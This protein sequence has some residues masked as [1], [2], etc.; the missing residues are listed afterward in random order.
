MNCK[1]AA[2]LIPLFIEA[3]LET[4][5]MQSLAE[6][7]EMCD[8]CRSVAEEFQ[9][10]QS[11]LHSVALPEFHAAAFAQMRNSVLNEI[12]RPKI[13]DLLHPIWDWKTAFAASLAMIILTSGAVNYWPDA[14]EN[15]VAQIPGNSDKKHEFSAVASSKDLVKPS[16]VSSKVLK[17]RRGCKNIARGEV[18]ASERNPGKIGTNHSSPERATAFHTQ[19]IPESVAPSETTDPKADLITTAIPK[20]ENTE[21]EMLR[22]ELQTAD[23]NIRII[24]F[25]PKET[26][27]ANTKADLR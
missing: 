7:L 21:P 18:S 27:A 17:P 10:S 3:D 12:A 9:A 19:I 23:P 24:W 20:P 26:I 2:Q 4:A 14:T 8:S 1:K 13:S 25:A 11:L 6:H 15:I 16:S 22:I 5:A